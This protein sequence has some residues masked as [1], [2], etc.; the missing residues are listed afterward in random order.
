MSFKLRWQYFNPATTKFSVCHNKNTVALNNKVLGCSSHTWDLKTLTTASLQGPANLPYLHICQT[1]CISSLRCS[2]WF[3]PI[4]LN[5]SYKSNLGDDLSGN[6]S[7]ITLFGHELIEIDARETQD[8]CVVLY[9]GTH[10][11]RLEL[12][13]L[14]QLEILPKLILKSAVNIYYKLSSI[15]KNNSHTVDDGIVP[16]DNLPD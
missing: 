12:K 7:G 15:L 5:A 2:Y 4:C 8:R 1:T 11:L 16:I 3:E 14:Q 10:Y 9:Y 13:R 6:V